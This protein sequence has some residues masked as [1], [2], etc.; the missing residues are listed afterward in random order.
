M[1]TKKKDQELWKAEQ[2]RQER[3]ERLESQRTR[4]G[5]K[6]PVR[7]KIKLA[8]IALIVVLLFII[9]G[10][11]L[12]TLMSRG[13]RE[14]HVTALEIA[15]EKIPANVVNFYASLSGQLFT[16]DFPQGLFAPDAKAN[17]AKPSPL[18]DGSEY[19]QDRNLRD[20]VL[21]YAKQQLLT[22]VVTLK[23][24]EKN[25]F[26]DSGDGLEAAEGILQQLTTAAAQSGSPLRLIL[27][28]Q[29][30]PGN[31]RDTVKE[32]VHNF[33][34]AEEYR[35]HLRK[36]FEPSVEEM[37]KAYAENPEKYD[38]AKF[39]VVQFLPTEADYHDFTSGEVLEAAETESKS[40]TAEDE[41]EEQAE[42]EENKE[43]EHSP[44]ELLENAKQ[45]AAEMQ[46]K[47]KSEE[48]FVKYQKSYANPQQRENLE[49]NPDSS[50]QR[51]MKANLSKEIAD[52]LF[53]DERKA[54][55]M[56]VLESNG[57][58]WLI[59]FLERGRNEEHS[60]DARHIFFEVPENADAEEEAKIKEQAEKVLAEYE[61][62]EKSEERFAELVSKYS[63]DQGS[64]D[65]GGLYQNVQ[66]GRF[67]DEFEDFV[68]TPG[69]KA[70]D[71]GL[72]R[73]SIGY[74]IIYFERLNEEIWQS[75]MKSEL[76][77]EGLSSWLQKATDGVVPVE[78]KGMKYVL[79]LK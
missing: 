56:D 18:R 30:G 10:L 65:N 73:S 45:R 25:G 3:K 1:S 62:G 39:R 32:L 37:E 43:P 69:R 21:M 60:Y 78:E 19:D 57:S 51:A 27:E 76:A 2:L 66:P 75:S 14:R 49:A 36:S 35:E 68:F 5:G 9:G 16:Q 11:I 20:D 31:N 74:H 61:A 64:V 71:V 4:S 29:Y 63:Q 55:D 40:E 46:T 50:I 23:E 54:G 47:V 15:G 58:A 33:I 28:S 8:N 70:G 79:P 77:Y 53:A 22:D 7:Q 48:D 6:K 24:A 12:N 26:K 42:K 13:Y 44:E 67:V 52:F 41:S 34:R 17:L 38:E 59:Y 72:V